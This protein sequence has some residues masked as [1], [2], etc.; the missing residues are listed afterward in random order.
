[1][2]RRKTGGNPARL[3]EAPTEKQAVVLERVLRW[4]ED[5]EPLSLSEVAAE[6]DMHYVTM[7]QHMEYLA[8]KG[9]LVFEHRGVGKRPIV[10]PVNSGLDYNVTGGTKGKSNDREPP[11]HHPSSD[12]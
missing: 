10:R 7:A 4:Y 5:R 6:L 3:D 2:A 11:P 12:C 9:F 8:A 1:M